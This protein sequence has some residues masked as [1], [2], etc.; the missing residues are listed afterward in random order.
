MV[1]LLLLQQGVDPASV[2]DELAGTEAAQKYHQV[3]ALEPEQL[4][5]GTLGYFVRWP[6]KDDCQRAAIATV[7]QVPPEELPDPRIDERLAAG[8]TAEEIDLSARRELHLWLAE[9]GL[10]M[11]VH[12]QLP[13][14]HRRWIGVAEREGAFMSHCLVMDRDEVLFDPARILGEKSGLRRWKLADVTFGLSFEP[15]TKGQESWA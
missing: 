15:L 6:R 5:D 4:P 8:E 9:H 3:I 10:E 11:V 12:Q 2:N 1:A 7:L 13:L 14:T